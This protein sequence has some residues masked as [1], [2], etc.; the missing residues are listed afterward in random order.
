M[1]G[2]AGEQSGVRTE[3]SDRSSGPQ[4]PIQGWGSAPSAAPAAV[5]LHPTPSTSLSP[6]RLGACTAAGALILGIPQSPEQP[7]FL[8][9]SPG[10]EGSVC[11]TFHAGPHPERKGQLLRGPSGSP[12]NCMHRC[13][14]LPCELWRMKHHGCYANIFMRISASCSTPWPYAGGKRNFPRKEVK[15]SLQGCKCWPLLL[16]GKEHHSEGSMCPPGSRC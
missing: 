5:L 1:T 6:R 9:H 15:T 12:G 7:H 3:S 11:L 10:A 13:K 14:G 16:L 4:S 2:P 8:P